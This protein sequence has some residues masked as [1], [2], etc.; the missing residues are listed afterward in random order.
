MENK[1]KIKEDED[2]FLLPV[3]VSTLPQAA[4]PFKIPLS[5]PSTNLQ[6]ETVRC[7]MQQQNLRNRIKVICTYNRNM[8]INSWKNKCRSNE[9][10]EEKF[11]KDAE[12]NSD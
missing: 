11:S 7:T 12:I 3:I 2:H 5:T 9:S 4:R 6:N 8:G 1:P 10:K